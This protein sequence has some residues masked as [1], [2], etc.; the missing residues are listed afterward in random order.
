MENEFDSPFVLTC[1]DDLAVIM[2]KNHPAY[3][4]KK[5]DRY[6]SLDCVLAN[7]GKLA[8]IADQ[9]HYGNNDPIWVLE[10]K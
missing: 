6:L 8:D 5:G 4:E 3:K 2:R 9:F 10:E 7:E 1:I